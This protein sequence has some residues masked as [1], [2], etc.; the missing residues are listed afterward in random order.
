MQ[1]F[2]VTILSLCCSIATFAQPNADYYNSTLDGKKGRELELVLQSIIHT[3]DKGPGKYPFTHRSYD[4]LWSLFETTDLAPADSI[5]SSYKGGKTDLVYDM[6]AWMDQF[7]KFYSDKNH[8]QTGGFNREHAVP[9][10]WWGGKDGNSYAYSD[11]HILMP[12]D[13]AANNQ[14][15]NH[16]LGE[17]HSGM[18][19]AWPTETMQNKDNY[20]YVDA[21]THDHS[22]GSPCEKNA[23]HIW[24][25]NNSELF[26]GA[27]TVFEPADVYKGDFARAYLY[28][29]CAYE[30]QLQWKE[31]EENTMFSNSKTETENTTYGYTVIS[32]W[33]KELLLRWH[34]QDP[35]SDKER[36]R[37]NAVFAIQNNRNPFVDYPELVEYIWG[38]KSS[39]NSFSLANALS[40]YSEEYKT[41]GA[42]DY[43]KKKSKITLILHAKLGDPFEGFRYSTDRTDDT[44]G[45]YSSS[46]TSVAKVDAN[47]GAITL[48]G[49]GTTTITYSI[50]ET[51]DFLAA[52]E[53]YIIEVVAE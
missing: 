5:P 11:L 36:N 39:N 30:G 34:R 25:V 16:P 13:G 19:L 31:K 12:A 23:T 38:N 8:T 51:E 2:Y 37:N 4:K 17:Y 40:S 46:D 44:V 41:Q 3:K 1:R 18:K 22:E 24:T 6:Y 48:V 14:K 29:V 21:D 47:T 28:L 45:T 50:S 9:N 32:D 10:S 33:A 27:T 20:I 42:E 49:A 7:P 43:G 53:S 26:G 52:E 15:S 35:V